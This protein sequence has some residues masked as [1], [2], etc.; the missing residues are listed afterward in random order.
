MDKNK[1]NYWTTLCWLSTVWSPNCFEIINPR[2]R[3][4]SEANRIEN[5]RRFPAFLSV[6][7]F[8]RTKQALRSLRANRISGENNRWYY[9]EDQH[10]VWSE[11]GNNQKRQVFKSQIRLTPVA[12]IP[13]YVRLSNTTLFEGQYLMNCN[14]IINNT[15]CYIH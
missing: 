12:E 8:P 6:G 9:L 15:F 14:N 1:I 5:V 3:I 11:F 10:R 2:L 13:Y 4:P 7:T